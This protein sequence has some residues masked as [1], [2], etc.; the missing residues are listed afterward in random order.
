M[1][2]SGYNK[3]ISTSRKDKVEVFKCF[4]LARKLLIFDLIVFLWFPI[5]KTSVELRTCCHSQTTTTDSN[6]GE[7]ECRKAFVI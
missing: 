1:L 3:K 2:N 7:R 5:R 4:Q 6:Q